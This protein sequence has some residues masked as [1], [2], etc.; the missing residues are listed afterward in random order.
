MA[1]EGQVRVIIK[2]KKG[3]HGAH[4]GAA[5]KVAYADFVTAMMALFM[6]LWLL[7]QA[8]L[9]LRSQIAQYFRIAGV[10][11]GGT[12]LSEERGDKS[13]EPK[14]VANDIIVLQGQ[15]EEEKL[16]GQAKKIEEAVKEVTQE[17]PELAA[18]QDQVMVQ[19]TEA[20][21]SIQF[22]DKGR[23]MLFDLSSPELKPAVV[24]VLRKLGTLLGS[25][26]NAIHVGGHTDSRPYPPSVKMT[27]WELSFRRADN[28]RRL[29][30]AN[31]LRPGQVRSVQAFADRMPLV[32]ENPLADENRRLS[33]LAERQGP[34][35]AKYKQDAGGE[36]VVLPPDTLPTRPAPAGEAAP[37]APATSGTPAAA[38][39]PAAPAAPA[40]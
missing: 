19:V 7:T 18:L 9:K 15:G 39:A 27:N 29:L 33:V 1:D 8:D 16:E 23:N 36:T 3:G 40:P 37:A 10:M 30:E 28:A 26:P 14:V 2:K 11:P 31:G 38:P 25:M 20:G 35:P 4:H 22:V 34:L 17:H 6:V 12:V 5:W 13:R 24:E 32:P 21:L